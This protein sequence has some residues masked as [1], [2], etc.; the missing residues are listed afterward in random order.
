MKRSS[1]I[2]KL[3]PSDI[4]FKQRTNKFYKLT[5]IIT[6]NASSFTN[7]DTES[8]SIENSAI[9]SNNSDED[10]FVDLLQISDDQGQNKRLDKYG[11]NLRKKFQISV[12]AGVAIAKSVLNDYFLINMIWIL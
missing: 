9:L 12:R 6:T 11:S 10:T 3:A 7:S 2:R 5:E 8:A 4:T 1:A